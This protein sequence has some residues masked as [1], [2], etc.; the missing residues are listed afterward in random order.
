MSAAADSLTSTAMQLLLTAERLIAQHGT[1]GVSLRQIASEAGSANNSAI[2]YHFGSKDELLRAI[3]AYRVNDLTHRRALLRS[4]ASRNDL[5]A[6]VEAHVVPLFELAEAPGSHYVAFVEQ[7]QRSGDLA[8]LEPQH[9]VQK[10]RQEFA[11][12]MQRLLTDVSEPVR[13][14][15]IEQAQ[16]LSLHLAAERERAVVRGNT[17]VPFALHVSSVVDGLTG[18]LSAPESDE[19][20]RLSE[21]ILSGRDS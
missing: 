9:E 2:Q 4:L 16:E 8:L 12:D 14:T 20:K 6:H 13:T 7:L 15:R 17:V 1:A 5:R 11:N 21:A 10:A 19:S 3:L 18:F